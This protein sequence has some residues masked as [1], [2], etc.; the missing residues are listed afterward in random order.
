MAVAMH[1]CYGNYIL[2]S[3]SA[4]IEL[5]ILGIENKSVRLVMTLDL[6]WDQS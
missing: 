1:V 6:T 2:S 4:F 3:N 5:Y